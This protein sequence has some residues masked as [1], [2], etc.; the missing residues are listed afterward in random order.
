MRPSSGPPLRLW[1]VVQFGTLG[2][3][4]SRTLR[5]DSPGRWPQEG[6]PHAM[7]PCPAPP[8]FWDETRRG[9]RLSRETRP[10]CERTRRSSR[11]RRLRGGPHGEGPH[12]A[13]MLEPA[14][15]GRGSAGSP[16]RRLRPRSRRQWGRVFLEAGAPPSSRGWQRAQFL[17]VVGLSS[18]R[19]ADCRP[20]PFPGRRTPPSSGPSRGPSDTAVAYFPES[21]GR[22]GSLF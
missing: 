21:A 10:S 1:N 8:R 9:G 4:L 19:P 2:F 13:H 12:S 22:T 20:R 7:R 15:S 5:K 18:P 6:K 3:P 11:G 14:A 16:A 17:V